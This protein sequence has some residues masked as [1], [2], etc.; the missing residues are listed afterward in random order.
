MLSPIPALWDVKKCDTHLVG[1]K[2]PLSNAFGEQTD[3][4]KAVYN[5][6]TLGNFNVPVYNVTLQETIKA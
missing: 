6:R 5:H 4:V 2:A 3:T 1:E